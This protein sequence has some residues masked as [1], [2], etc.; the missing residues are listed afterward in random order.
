M[1]FC[2]HCGAKVEKSDQKFC[3]ACGK[4]LALESKP[5]HEKETSEKK[6]QKQR[7]KLWSNILIIS[8]VLLCVVSCI[9]WI[10]AWDSA[11]IDFNRQWSYRDSQ[12]A[13]EAANKVTDHS[14]R[15]VSLVVVLEGLSAYIAFA[16]AYHRNRLK[17]RHFVIIAIGFVFLGLAITGVITSGIYVPERISGHMHAWFPL[18]LTFLALFATVLGIWIRGK[19]P[20]N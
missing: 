20:V 9:A 4:P 11:I 16:V 6:D 7:T 1:S 10:N 2:P 3:M 8:G 12:D 18:T 5:A 13:V 19:S 17:A 15:T 14:L